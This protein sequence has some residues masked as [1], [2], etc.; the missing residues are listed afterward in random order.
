M[1]A[2]AGR[3]TPVQDGADHLAAKRLAGVLAAVADEAMGPLAHAVRLDRPMPGEEAAVAAFRAARAA[4]ALSGPGALP[5]EAPGAGPRGAGATSQITERR[6]PGEPG[7]PAPQITGPVLGGPATGG[8]PGVRG[9]GTGGPTAHGPARGASARGTGVP[10]PDVPGT[11]APGADVRGLDTQGADTQGADAQG[12][13]ARGASPQGRGTLVGARARRNAF[14]PAATGVVGRADTGPGRRGKT[15]PGRPSSVGRPLRAG[16]AAALVGCALG[17]VAVAT[18][19][20]MLPTPFRS[21]PQPAPASSVTAAESPHGQ[22]PQPKISEASEAS[23]VG[24]SGSA[25]AYEDG[26]GSTGPASAPPGDGS[27]DPG[28]HPSPGVGDTD[29]P[30]GDHGQEGAD[31]GSDGRP[32]QQPPRW[33]PDPNKKRWVV[34]MC[35]EYVATKNGE[36]TALDSH[37]LLKLERAAGGAD[38]VRTFCK[39][40]LSGGSGEGGSRPGGGGGGGHQDGGPAGDHGGDHDGEHGGGP[41]DGDHDGGHS[42]G[43]GD[44]GKPPGNGG[45]PSPTPTPSHTSSSSPTVTETVIPATNH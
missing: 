41:G 26:V 6:A 21:G 15:T 16:F 8:V 4:A 44:A 3:S 18:G 39:G 36:D 42:D 32:S 11:D 45:S 20:G 5:A 7:R 23:S 10:G 38:A 28:M 31:T 43:G 33:T 1:G 27:P 30:G 14:G 9:A 24:P 17:G 35:R 25:P 2:V 19:T 37:T 12:Y 22:L 40:V 13:G 29:D 34:A